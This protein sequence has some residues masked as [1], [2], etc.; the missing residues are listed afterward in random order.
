MGSSNVSQ[1]SRRMKLQI[2]AGNIPPWISKHRRSARLIAHYLS[3]PLWVD[4]RDFKHLRDK[5]IAETKRTGIRH[6]LDHIV[7]VTHPFVCGLTVPWN[8]QVVPHVVNIAKGN[9]WHPDQQCF[10]LPHHPHQHVLPL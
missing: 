5:A 8:M 6:T 1:V 4:H 9:K 7:P 10:D 3:A 2:M